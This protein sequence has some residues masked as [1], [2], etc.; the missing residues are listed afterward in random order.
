MDVPAGTARAVKCVGRLAGDW[1]LRVRRRSR[2]CSA[3]FRLVLRWAA[4]ERWVRIGP[5]RMPITYIDDTLYHTVIFGAVDGS[6]GLQKAGRLDGGC[7]SIATARVSY[8]NGCISRGPPFLRIYVL[9]KNRCRVIWLVVRLNKKSQH[10][11]I[12]CNIMF[13]RSGV[14]TNGCDDAFRVGHRII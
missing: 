11:L 7:R 14:L 1:P 5:Q 13:T 4:R 9:T 10:P 6:T 3:P 2:D 8:G 12:I